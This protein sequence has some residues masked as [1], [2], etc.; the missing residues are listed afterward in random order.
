MSRPAPSQLE[1]GDLPPQMV[2]SLDDG[3][4]AATQPLLDMARRHEVAGLSPFFD[5]A[6]LVWAEALGA[7]VLDV[8][9]NRYVDLLSG[10]GVA[11]IGH[12]HPRV[13]AALTSQSSRLVHGLGDAQGHDLRARLAARLAARLP[14]AEP[15][16]AFAVSG[17][18]AVEL[19]IK[20]ALLATGRGRLLV[21]EPSYHGMTLGALAATSRPAFRRV[22]DSHL[23]SHLVRVPFGADGAEL[24]KALGSDDVAA[25]IVE[26]IVGRE[27]VLVPPAGWLAELG[28]SCRRH[29]ALL[30]ADEIL[31]GCGRTG[32]WFATEHEGVEPDLV[33][34]GKALGGGLPIAAVAGRPEVMAAWNEPGEA[35]HTGTFVA[36]P[37]ACAAALAS[38]E[39]LDGERLVERAAELATRLEP[40]LSTWPDRFAAVTA[41][42]GRGALWGVELSSAAS[43]R[44]FAR[45]ARRRGVLLLVGG[46]E[47]RVAELAP[48]LVITDRQYEIALSL[49]EEAAL[50]AGEESTTEPVP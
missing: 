23:H 19:A 31:T 46:P 21:F 10:F 18:D 22:A 5:D 29:G 6:P 13:V 45:E 30:I 12:R 37:L 35:R 14:F 11:A 16:I 2:S 9:G 36:H 43:G 41:V 1:R 27:G 20:T 33:C 28:E 7:N 15:R 34:C 24:E 48:P 39:V 3:P 49:L 47:G 8:E 50:V 42:R 25:A 32:R 38:L 40:R 4:G 26:P 44:R 17:A